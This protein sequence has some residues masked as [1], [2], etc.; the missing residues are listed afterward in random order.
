MK[1][2][3]RIM[4]LLLNLALLFS[5]I[6][7]PALSFAQSDA[8]YR[9]SFA[10][11]GLY[12]RIGEDGKRYRSVIYCINGDPETYALLTNDQLNTVA[13]HIVSYVRGDT[14]DFA[15]Y[16]DRVYLNDGYADNVRIF[17]DKA[18]AHMA[19]VRS[20]INVAKVAATVLCALLPLLLT[21]VILRRR[22]LGRL[23][24]RY[25]VFFYLGLASVALIFVLLTAISD[26]GE[27]G[28]VRALWRNVH[29]LFFP[30]QP[31]KVAGSFFNDALTYIL[32]L[33]LFMGAVYAILGILAATLL[34]FALLAAWLKRCAKEQ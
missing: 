12:E 11:T 10:R 26:G 18:I 22:T 9:R 30:F 19:D 17:G 28:L 15:L 25:T 4:I 23:I 32:R 2:F 6:L 29:Y 34:L 24:W 31:E 14:E 5:A 20:L 21:Y 7:I 33:D 13:R 1:L 8:Y 16:M 27:F 3:D